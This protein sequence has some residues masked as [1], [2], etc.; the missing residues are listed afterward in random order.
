MHLQQTKIGSRKSGG[1]QYWLQDPP[2]EVR[3]YLRSKRAVP[4]AL[5]TPYGITRSDFMALDRNFKLSGEKVVTANAQHDRIQQA[6]ASGSIGEAIR[7]WYA[8]PKGIDFERIGIEVEIRDGRFYVTPV[9][10]KLV[11]RPSIRP[12]IRPENPLSFHRNFQS[13]LWRTQLKHAHSSNLVGFR[14]AVGEIKRIVSE[15]SAIPNIDEKDLLR[16]SGPLHVLGV[17]LGPYVKRGYDCSGS[18]RFLNYRPYEVPVEIKTLSSG[19]KYQT[20]KY[21]KEQLSRAVVLCLKHNHV[22]ISKHVDVIDLGYF[23]KA[24]AIHDQV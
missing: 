12:I 13:L 15:Q 16:A 23:A 9:A 2:D 7:L 11:G 24:D 6:R 5:M 22:N 19:F 8:L 3:T 20:Q 17:Q 14:W 18:F 1:P 4:V 10:Y 21:G